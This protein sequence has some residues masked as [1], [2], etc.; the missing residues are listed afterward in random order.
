M[1][2]DKQALMIQVQFYL[3]ELNKSKFVST[4]KLLVGKAGGYLPQIPG[5][6]GRYR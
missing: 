1:M 6:T 5:K 3:I 2:R 4:R